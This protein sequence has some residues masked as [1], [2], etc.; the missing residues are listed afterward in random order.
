MTAELVAAR[1]DPGSAFDG[2]DAAYRFQLQFRF[3][4]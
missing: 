4:F 1:F 2:Q 3:K